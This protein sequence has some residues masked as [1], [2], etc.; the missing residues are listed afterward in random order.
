MKMYISH[1]LVSNTV[2]S[3]YMG[4][5]KVRHIFFS[6]TAAKLFLNAF[7]L[8]NVGLDVYLMKSC[9]FFIFYNSYFYSLS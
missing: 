9:L 7:Q 4:L 2:N 3:T 1:L 8:A 5:F 6:W